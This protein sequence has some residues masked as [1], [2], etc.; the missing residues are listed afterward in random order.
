[1]RRW[2]PKEDALWEASQGTDLYRWPGTGLVTLEPVFLPEAEESSLERWNLSGTNADWKE[3]KGVFG[4]NGPTLFQA[5]TNATNLWAISTFTP[6]DNQPFYLD[7]YSYATYVKTWWADFR[8]CRRYTIRLLANGELLLWRNFNE[9]GE[10]PDW[11][12]V[13][14]AKSTRQ[15]AN[16]LL[17]VGVYATAYGTL[18]I[19]PFEG[20]SL[21]YVDSEPIV[22]EDFDEEDEVSETYR[23]IAPAYPVTVYVSSGSCYL[24]YRYMRFK[25]SGGVILPAQRLPEPCVGTY[26]LVYS[27]RPNRPDHPWGATFELSDATGGLIG[28][29]PAAS[30]DLFYPTVQLTSE[31]EEFSPELLWL[32]MGIEASS[33]LFE[34]P[35]GSWEIAEGGHL[36][37]GLEAGAALTDRRKAHLTL[38]NL[39][40][41][42]DALWRKLRM[43]SQIAT[44]EEVVWEGYTEDTEWRFTQEGNEELAFSGADPLSRLDTAASDACIGD[45]LLHTEHVEAIF[46]QC[47]LAPTDY[48]I[49]DDPEGYLLPESLGDEDPLFQVRDGKSWREYLEYLCTNW[50]GW[51]IWTEA[52]GRLHYGLRD[53]SGSAMLNLTLSE[54]G[55]TADLKCL[56]LTRHRDEADFYN[57]I[58]VIGLG[59][60]SRSITAFYYDTASIA[61]PTA[62]NYLGFEKSLVVV[63]PNFRTEE[64]VETALG[65]VVA[66]HGVLNE[67]LQAECLWGTS[68]DIGDLVTVEGDMG[69]A[70]LEGKPI[71]VPYRYQVVD[72]AKTWNPDARLRLRARKLWDLVVPGE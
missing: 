27:V 10:T 28:N 68:L 41:S 58:A 43:R 69:T 39:D 26:D 42:Y 62:D 67:D 64:Q 16:R 11:Q 33:V 36:Q 18:I 23:T 65:L 19:Q 48:I 32:Q 8:F 29:P 6:E 17:R 20:D 63:D 44:D 66:R 70:E 55:G 51:D 22:T 4:H 30:F 40:S 34:P 71:E 50:T 60:D 14:Q 49:D 53:N 59:H 9:G 56:S 15:V 54:T 57:S 2:Y 21:I 37:D 45:G 3:V 61:D 52:D 31:D 12:L 38:N 72:L 24:S 47:G 25:T 35:G 13:G 7:F 46:K 5:A 1:M